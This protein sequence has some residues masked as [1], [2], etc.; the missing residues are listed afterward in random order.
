MKVRIYR[1]ATSA[2]MLAVFAE[3]LGAGKKWN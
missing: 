1:W 3:S 2:A